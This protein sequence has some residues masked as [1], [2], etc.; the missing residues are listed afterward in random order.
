MADRQRKVVMLMMATLV[1][2]EVM[3]WR[4]KWE[5][6]RRCGITSSGGGDEASEDPTLRGLD[7]RKPSATIGLIPS[8]RN[9]ESG[10]QNSDQRITDHA[11]LSK[12]LSPM[13]F[14]SHVKI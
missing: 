10:K 9:H 12:H 6:E 13:R 4:R 8:V 5:N 7:W 14:G 3:V 11:K 2:E 1:G